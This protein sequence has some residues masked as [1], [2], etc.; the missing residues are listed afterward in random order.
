MRKILAVLGLIIVSSY[1]SSA[2][3]IQGFDTI[4]VNTPVQLTTDQTNASS[5]YWGFCSA[6]LNNTPQGSSI[7]A[8]TGLDNPRSIALVVDEATDEHY[9]FVVNDGGVTRNVM[10][11]AF[12][13]SLAN[14]PVA[15]N[16]GDF[17]GIINNNPK[18]LWFA[19]D[20]DGWHAFLAAGNAPGASQIIRFDFTSGLSAIPTAT[21]LGNL[22]GLIIN[23][24][25]MYIF[26]E[27]GN[28]HGFTNSGFTGDLIRLDF[29]P[30]L[31]AVPSVLT[32]SNFAS[33]PPLGLAFPTGFWPAFDG[34]D[35][36]LFVCNAITSSVVRL[37]FGPSLTNATPGST[38]LGDFGGLLTTP[39]DISI[40][41]DCGAWYGFVNNEGNNNMVR[42]EFQGALNAVPTATD[43]GNFAGF[44][45]PLYLTQ[46]KRSRD[47]VFAFT[48]NN[49]SSSLS[50]IEFN[51]CL[52]P[53][54]NSSIFRTPPPIT[55][56]VP[57]VYNVYLAIDEGLP[58]MQ[59]V[60]K[61]I[62]V[63]PEPILAIH[64]DT[65]IC[66]GDTI[67]VTANGQNLDSLIWSTNYNMFPP[68]ADTETVLLYPRENFTYDIHMVFLGG[69]CL[70]DTNLDITVSQVR[71]DAGEDRFVAD[72]SYTTLGGPQISYGQEYSYQ[73]TPSTFLDDASIA[74]PRCDPKN[75]QFYIL[76]VTNDST[77]CAVTDSVFVFNECTDINL[78]NAFNPVSDVSY[79][80]EFGVLNNRLF[81][82]NY[83]RIY[84]RWG[85]LIF[86][87]TNPSI[88]WDGN[89]LNIPAPSG[90]YIW[91]VD[92]ECDNGKRIQK[93][94]NVFLVR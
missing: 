60:C 90:T 1:S 48:A 61:Q 3:L 13:N 76:E 74:N 77:G 16:M 15:T 56:D 31:S 67:Q 84:N 91:I 25:D 5:Y 21:D 23:P 87:T 63:L 51:S 44:N 47:N 69:G 14:A 20:G 2:Q 82:L 24:Q 70:I 94:G 62:T 37:D 29:G 57:G 93:Q 83:F 28:W 19:E 17:G 88:Q 22:G 18:G 40:I 81:K 64:N 33:I 26:E 53:D 4:C 27:G 75:T 11:Y 92:G 42:L 36:Y 78:P 43:L 10:R 32:I 7:A 79:N 86:E 72:G 38:D 49:G 39:R 35:W 71:A 6:Y 58:S 66:A 65:L 41:Q 46:F 55:Y 73:W 50:R 8:G 80:R 52:V 45:A 59:V 89:H 9:I 85:N 12:G 30:N 68:T 34:T 54:L